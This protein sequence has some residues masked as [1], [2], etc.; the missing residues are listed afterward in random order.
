M[1]E[2]T[3]SNQ[4]FLPGAVRKAQ[5]VGRKANNTIDAVRQAPSAMRFPPGRRGQKKVVV[6]LSGGKDSTAAVILLKEK[7]Y[8]VRAVTMKI[9]IPGEDERL[10]KIQHLV[11]VLKI[12]WRVV[13]LAAEFKEK[14]IDYFVRSYAAGDTP[15]PCAVCNNEIKFNL[16]MQEALLKEQADFYATGHY[17]KK[18][19]VNG[20]PFLTEPEDR[21]KS[22]IYFLAMIGNKALQRVI[23]P[24][25]PLT[26]TEV[27]KIVEG[28]PLANRKESQD[29]C[30]LGNNKL[31]D[32]LKNHLPFH[33]FKPG[34]ILDVYGHIIGR[35]KGA[36]YFTIGQRRGLRFSSDRKLYVIKKDVGCSTIT[37]GEK[38]Y[39]Y[40]RSVKVT[41]PV[42]W[43][44]IKVGETLKAKFRYKSSF[45][46]A[47][48]NE[49]SGDS[50]IALFP[51]PAKSIT[52]GQIAAFYDNDIIVAAGYIC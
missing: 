42:F 28:F 23:F 22:Q 3:S 49:V 17:A 48:I 7:N 29:V 20:H 16:L 38:K 15:N 31:M 50:I 27:R 5:S 33:Y 32:F 35:H 25:S 21:E 19:T 40:T 34:N 47:I 13:D 2:E 43:R 4:K 46:K 8:D 37:L 1:T 30:F 9:G 24:L 39:L 10:E 6:A 26:I 44:D 51:E 41:K 52:P 36:V 45:Y 18:I 11:E 12:P 14:V